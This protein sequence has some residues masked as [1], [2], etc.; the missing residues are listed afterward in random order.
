LHRRTET[1]C[2]GTCLVWPVLPDNMDVSTHQ[3]ISEK[4]ATIIANTNSMPYVP[5][6]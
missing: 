3:D 4:L 6:Y 1:G 2:D 5:G